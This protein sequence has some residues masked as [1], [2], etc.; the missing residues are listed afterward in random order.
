MP[1]TNA[2]QPRPDFGDHVSIVRLR[3]AGRPT[4][5]GDG[6][7]QVDVPSR[8]LS[9]QDLE[10]LDELFPNTLEQAHRLLACEAL[11]SAVVK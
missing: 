7:Y 9:K 5:M 8:P 3:L 1:N 4:D 11:L 6:T 10:L 2:N